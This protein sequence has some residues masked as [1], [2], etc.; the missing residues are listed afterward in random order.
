MSR[1]KQKYKDEVIPAMMEEF[2]YSTPMQVPRL[3]KIVLNTG[4]G[5][6]VANSKAMD[7]V[8][9]VMTQISGQKPV[10]TRAKKSIATYKLRE[11]QPIGC[12]VTMRQQKMFDFMD[13]LITVALPRVRDF[14][15]TPRKGFDGRGNY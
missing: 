6:A 8:V 5:E 13:R 10:I 3:S 1:V 15:G 9:Y 2:G 7:F 4:V 14:R 12:M 11:G